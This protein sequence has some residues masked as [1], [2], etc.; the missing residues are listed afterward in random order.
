MRRRPPY[1][2]TGER[3]L[4][5][6]KRMRIV[7]LGALVIAISILSVASALI[8]AETGMP[9]EQ[10]GNNDTDWKVRLLRDNGPSAHV[11]ANREGSTGID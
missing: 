10:S 5:Q 7:K 6:Q 4:R 3:V 2:W 1:D 9:S 8:V 11:L